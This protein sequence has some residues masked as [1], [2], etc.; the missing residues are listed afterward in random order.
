MKPESYEAFY[1]RAKA[2][3]DL[4]MYESSLQDVKEAAKLAPGHNNEV[5]KVLMYLQE[6][7]VNK[8]S[9]P[10]RIS[11]QRDFAVS[12]DTLHEWIVFGAD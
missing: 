7:I 9:S 10:A 12:V 6:E 2:K 11:N 3:L 4:R 1:A 5:R 8:M